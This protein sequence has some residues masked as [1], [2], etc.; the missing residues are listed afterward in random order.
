[1]GDGEKREVWWVIEQ[2]PLLEALRRC[3]NGESADI[4]LMELTANADVE[5]IDRSEDE[6]R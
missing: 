1:M 3:A 6:E 5:T 4:V 2:E